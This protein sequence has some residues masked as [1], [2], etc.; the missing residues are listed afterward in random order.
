[1]TP[2]PRG[3][4][5]TF[6]LGL[7]LAAA[8]IARADAPQAGDLLGAKFALIEAAPDRERVCAN[9]L[10]AL[11]QPTVY[12]PNDLHTSLLVTEATRVWQ[13]V[14]PR[15]GRRRPANTFGEY[16]SREDHADVVEADL[17]HDG[18][19]ED[20]YRV[21]LQ[22]KGQTYTEVSL[23]DDGRRQPATLATLTHALQDI[24]RAPPDSS[25]FLIDILD[26]EDADYLIA[27]VT[28]ESGIERHNRLA[29]VAHLRENGRLAIDCTL[30][31]TLFED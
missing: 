4:P 9:V 3:V 2:V 17:D 10:R 7:L 25:F 15:T 13:I 5:T 12:D 20:A 18:V 28:V 8:P 11:N 21:W 27:L 6:M 22:V 31:T 14:D 24:G 16:R 23:S 26:I 1:M 29:Y 30:K 19:P